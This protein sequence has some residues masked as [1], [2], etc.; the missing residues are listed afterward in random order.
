VL[1]SWLFTRSWSSKTSPD[2]AFASIGPSTISLNH[3]NS[4]D[5]YKLHIHTYSCMNIFILTYC[6]CV[7]VIFIPDE[8]PAQRRALQKK[9]P[10]LMQGDPVR[11]RSVD[12]HS[13]GFNQAQHQME[14][15]TYVPPPQKKKKTYLFTIFTGIYGVFCIFWG[16]CFYVLLNK[17]GNSFEGECHIIY[18][19]NRG[20]RQ[21]CETW[22]FWHQEVLGGPRTSLEPRTKNQ[23]CTES[24]GGILVLGSWF[25]GGPRGP[26][27]F[28]SFQTMS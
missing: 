1:V 27:S 17:F 26:L 16:I 18:I 4:Y 24:F 19:Y 22:W 3:I 6:V 8:A 10:R 21:T 7:Y 23:D 9:P 5:A 2:V 25:Q 20:C 15:Y 14:V 28:S 11:F 13:N 12:G